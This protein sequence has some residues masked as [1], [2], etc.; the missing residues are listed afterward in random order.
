MRTHHERL[1]DILDAID[2][3]QRFLPTTMELLQANEERQVW[4]V[5]HLQIIGEASRS[6]SDDIR[7]QLPTIPWRKW[8]GLRHILV[9][10]YFGIDIEAVYQAVS[11]DFDRMKGAIVTWIDQ[12][13]EE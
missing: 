10:E 13:P 6:I 2:R 11:S 4:F 1:R 9:H 12:Y 8:V 3:I 5:H 7:R